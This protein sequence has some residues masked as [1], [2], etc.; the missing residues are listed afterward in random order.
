VIQ[1]PG[2]LI[3]LPPGVPSPTY[4]VAWWRDLLVLVALAAA[5]CDARARRGAALGLAILFAML[6]TGFW[7]CALARPYGVLVEAGITTWAADVSVAGG[8]GGDERFLAG[9]PGAR[10]MWTVLAHRIRPDLVLLIPSVLPVLILPAVA[11]LIAGLWGRKEATLAAILWLG[12]ATGALDLARGDGFVPGLWSRPLA[13]LAWV[14]MVAAVLLVARLPLS[15]RATAVLGG[16]ILAGWALLGRRGPPIGAA[17]AWLALTFDSHLWFLLGALGL[18]RTRDPAACALVAGGA[19]LTLMRALVGPGDAWAGLA[20]CR[21]GLVLGTTEC[22]TLALAA[23]GPRDLPEGLARVMARGGALPQRLPGA[24]IVAL[25]LGGGLLAWWDPPKVDAIAR[26]SLE[27]VPE[28]LVEAMDWMR[29]RTA[30]ESAVLAADEYAPAVSVMAG[31]RVLRA[32]GLLTAPDEERRVRLERAVLAG[33]L[34]AALVQRYG[35]RYVFIAPGQFREE[36]IAQ[37]EDLDAHAGL[38]L[39]YANAKGMRIYEIA[40]GP[41]GP[42]K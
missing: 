23:W 12:G 17:D 4:D 25:V 26:E 24:A 9:E 16:L 18:W 8:A 2:A 28:A 11:A 19:V 35:L 30:P 42:I 20:F 7:I 10:T 29:T 22:L 33:H 34:P 39:V 1:G 40:P 3:S 5:V 32:P 14:A 13:S 41:S 15:P 36:G 37:P 31:R 21:L 38:R 6:A 27:P